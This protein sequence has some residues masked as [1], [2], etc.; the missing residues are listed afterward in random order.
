LRNSRCFSDN[1][2]AADSFSL[3]LLEVVADDINRRDALATP[4]RSAKQQNDEVKQLLLKVCNFLA[5]QA[6]K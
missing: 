3:L 2:V 4:K 5:K 1:A 6:K